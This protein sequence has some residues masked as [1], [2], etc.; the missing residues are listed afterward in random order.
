[1]K[2]KTQIIKEY[3]EAGNYV[4]EN[5]GIILTKYR[6]VPCGKCIECLQK[7]Q[8]ELTVLAIEESKKFNTMHFFTLTYNPENVPISH[9]RE[10]VSTVTGEVEGYSIHDVVEKC[11][12]KRL[13]RGSFK[14]R[15]FLEKT[16]YYYRWYKMA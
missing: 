7:K 10:Y 5:T 13:K 12:E 14:N 4:D 15:I 11:D 16:A 9:T 1:M 8:V 3:L 6:K 2:T